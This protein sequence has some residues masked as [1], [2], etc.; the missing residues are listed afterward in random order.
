MRSS[1]LIDGVVWDGKDPEEVRRRLQGRAASAPDRE[2]PTMVSA[3]FHSPRTPPPLAEP[4]AD[5]APSRRQPTGAA[6]AAAALPCPAAARPP[7]DP[8]DWRGLAGTVL[9]PVM[10]WRCWSASGRCSRKRAAASHAGG[11]LRGRG[12]AVRDPFYRKGP[13]DQGIGWNVL[14]SLER[15]AVGFGLAALVGIPLGFDRPLRRSSAACS[16]R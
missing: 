1:K 8:F 15:V 14:F 9:P 3:V 7:R 16:T 6:G 10:G 12:Q 4:R 5:P 11:H 2:E 13:N